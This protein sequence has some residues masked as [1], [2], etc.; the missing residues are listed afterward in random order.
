M[1]TKEQKAAIVAEFGK[2]A[3][4]TGTPRVQVA[5]LT[6]RIRELTEHCKQHP[7]DFHSR[8]GLLMLAASLHPLQRYQRVS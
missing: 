4:D 3:N 6:A 1:V 5:L 2:D 8:R 7:H